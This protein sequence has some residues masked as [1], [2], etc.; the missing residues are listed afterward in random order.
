MRYIPEILLVISVCL[1]VYGLLLLYGVGNAV[2]GA[3]VYLGVVAF[4]M[5]KSRS[6]VE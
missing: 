1:V 5:D 4:A 3:G 2:L 6:E